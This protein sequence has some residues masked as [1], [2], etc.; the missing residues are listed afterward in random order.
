[1]NSI[2]I[3]LL[4]ILSKI[5]SATIISIIITIII[6]I[7]VMRILSIVIS[8]IISNIASYCFVLFQYVIAYDII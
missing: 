5:P 8:A 3:H 2:Q 6:D 1:M 7:S 4:A